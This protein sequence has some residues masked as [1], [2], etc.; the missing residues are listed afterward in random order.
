MLLPLRGLDPQAAYVVTD[1]D[2]PD[3]PVTVNGS[4]LQD[5]GLRV[6]IQAVSQAVVIVYRRSNR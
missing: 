3:K 1:M 6:A 2:Q 4:T 5:E